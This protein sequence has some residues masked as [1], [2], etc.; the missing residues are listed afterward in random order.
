MPE[1][2]DP[3]WEYYQPDPEIEYAVHWAGNKSINRVPKL[4]DDICFSI[5]QSR[6]GSKFDNYNKLFTEMW[7]SGHKI[8][9][10]MKKLSISNL[11]TIASWKEKLG[12]PS[13]MP[14]NVST[15]KQMVYVI[16]HI[17]WRQ[18]ADPIT[19][20]NCIKKLEA[21]YALDS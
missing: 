8:P 19:V 17:K 2:F 18:L 15:K 3:K 1:Y 7:L 5:R 10:I 20:R 14:G 11:A 16:K 9:E 6:K 12:L 21:N 13:R 4:G